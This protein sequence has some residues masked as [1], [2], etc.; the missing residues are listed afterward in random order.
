MKL[1][2]LNE[3]L[4]HDK[5]VGVRLLFPPVEL[6]IER[7]TG[8]IVNPNVLTAKSAE[9]MAHYSTIAYV[10]DDD[11]FAIFEFDQSTLFGL[12][13]YASRYNIEE[14]ELLFS[15]EVNGKLRV[16][17]G[18][19]EGLVKIDNKRE[20]MRPAYDKLTNKYIEKIGYIVHDFQAI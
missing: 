11:S 3:R 4:V 9:V 5:S 10:T 19:N 16:T 6:L 15:R 8:K 1:A 7:S 18:K 13:G 12:Q 2:T 17:I 14:I 20:S